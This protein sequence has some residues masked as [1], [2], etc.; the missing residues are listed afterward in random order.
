MYAG[1]L[2]AYFNWV[3][4]AV[5]A[6]AVLMLHLQVLQ[7]EAYLKDVFG[8]KYTA[9]QAETCRYFGRKR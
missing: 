4:L 2:L 9:Y 7:E 3:L 6:W 8:E 5:T 1:I